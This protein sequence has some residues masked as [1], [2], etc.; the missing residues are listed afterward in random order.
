MP[1][2]QFDRSKL[3]LKPLSERKNDLDLS[4]LVYP[5]SAYQRIIQPDL[6]AI[7]TRIL[8]ARQKGAPVVLMMGAHVIRKGNSP[9]DRKSVV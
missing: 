4:V 2:P 1:F 3:I 8:A 6:D 7:T 9:L 5:D